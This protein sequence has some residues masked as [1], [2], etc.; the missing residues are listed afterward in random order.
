M[1]FKTL[2]A[3][4]QPP[5]L[6]GRSFCNRLSGLQSWQAHCW[7]SL[8]PPGVTDAFTPPVILFSSAQSEKEE[9]SQTQ[10]VI[11][12]SGKQRQANRD[13]KASLRSL[14]LRPQTTWVN[15]NTVSRQ[16][17]CETGAEDFW[18][19]SYG[20]VWLSPANP[21]Y[22][23]DSPSSFQRLATDKGQMFTSERPWFLEEKH[24]CLII[25]IKE[26]SERPKCLN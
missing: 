17:L 25:R 14:E 26:M 11:L 24:L 9:Q 10:C 20:A 1:W 2:K 13:F 7:T 23:Y 16:I 3:P 4:Y 8:D 21:Q 22:V 15:V 18:W 5:P 6:I 19:V 12:A